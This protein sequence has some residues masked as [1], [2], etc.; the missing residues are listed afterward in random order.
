M[1][2]QAKC[3]ISILE[4]YES[5]KQT[6]TIE[7]FT[8]EAWSFEE[9][10]ETIHMHPV[11]TNPSENIFKVDITAVISMFENKPDPVRPQREALSVTIH[12]TRESAAHRHTPSDLSVY[13]QKN[14][15]LRLLS[16]AG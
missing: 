5:E 9:I 2:Y 8:V 13:S 12:L 4:E 7:T 15:A 10:M 14:Q 11:H 3:T 16:I 6:K 1:R